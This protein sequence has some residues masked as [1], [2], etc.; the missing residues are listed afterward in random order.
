MAY[1]NATFY[2]D[3]ESGTDIART[4]LTSVAVSNNGS[5]LVRCTK[6]AHG[7]VTGAVGTATLNYAGVWM[8][9]VID[10][11]NFD[12]VDS[13]YSTATALTFTPFGGSSKTDAW[14]TISTGATAARIQP[15]DTCRIKASPVETL[16]GDATWTQ[17]SPTVTLPG[18]VT[19][20]ICTCETSW[21]TSTNVVSTTDSSKTKLGAVSTRISIAS[22]FTTGKVAYFA[23]GTLDLSAYQ[24]VS[25]FV[26]NSVLYTAGPLALQ[27]CTDAIGDVVVHSIPIPSNP[28]TNGYFVPV[29]M[30]F[31]VP[32]DSAINSISLSANSDPGAIVL[33]FDNIIACKA[34]ASAD[35]VSLISLVG[36]VWNQSWIASTVHAANTIRRPTQANRNGFCYKVTAGGG[37]SSGGTEPAWPLELGLTVVD[38]ALTWTCLDLEESWYPIQSIS[39]TAI[40]LDTG[41]NSV[42]GDSNGYDG[43]T[44]T[45]ATY[46]R[47]TSKLAVV[48]TTSTSVSQPVDS[49]TVAAQI[50]FSGGW[51]RTSM[52]TRSGETW[53][54]A[55]NSAPYGTGSSTTGASFITMD[56]M[57]FVRFGASFLGYNSQG[58]V[59][60][61]C[62]FVGNNTGIT[63]ASTIANAT[64]NIQ[65]TGVQVNNCYGVGIA[66][67]LNEEAT[68]FMRNIRVSNNF[69]SGISIASGGGLNLRWQNVVCKNNSGT[70]GIVSS[71]G[72][73]LYIDGLVTG[74]NA[75]GISLTKGKVFLNKADIPEATQVTS[76]TAKVGATVYSMNQVGGGHLI[77]S[78][79]GTIISATDQRNTASGISWKFRPTG[80]NR[81][82]LYPL[83]LSMVKIACEAN[84]AVNVT[85]YTY[86]D[87]TDIMGRL[88]LRGGQIAGVPIDLTVACSPT[89]ST[90]EQSSPL[91]FTPT[92]AGVV[93]VLFEVYDGV[94]TTN[95]F[96]IDDVAVTA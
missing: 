26:S 48:S 39:G 56:G 40:T 57:N 51:D 89:V 32:L 37:G 28:S 73:P 75:A 68:G 16:I 5:G 82:T 86:R 72:V 4:A 42:I 45:V 36:K 49:G 76:L 44:E 91:T 22:G 67:S 15:G 20:D 29:T 2:I 8:I 79:S 30:D 3:Y 70:A 47:E 34:S 31:G 53:L 35:S 74:S 1:S 7:L 71:S 13:T 63:F 55:S 88:R 19:A 77:T 62:H 52:A 27:L 96:W 9:T 17:Y 65:M 23:T 59:V 66:T 81:T 78:D 87:H 50:T 94:G 10:A 69:L 64:T 54:D 33:Y 84:V 58:W 14:K 46:K 24:Q 12:L 38:G 11:N 6:T 61:N 83:Q 95:N 80:V 25:F 90:W 85:V 43:T 92:E 18:A 93:E 21:T 41:N 60:K